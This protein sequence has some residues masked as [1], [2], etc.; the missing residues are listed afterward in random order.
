M[1]V[2]S[3]TVFDT[4][5]VPVRGRWGCVP[6]S[7]PG[8]PLTRRRR[9]PRPGTRSAVLARRARWRRSICAT[10]LSVGWSTRTS[11]F[12]QV[13]WAG[14]AL[15]RS[16]SNA[17]HCPKRRAWPTPPSWRRIDGLT[18]RAPPPRLRRP[19]RARGGVWSGGARGLRITAGLVVSDRVCAPIWRRPRRTCVRGR[20][21]AGPALARQGR[22]HRG[23][24]SR[25]HPALLEAC[26]ALLGD[27]ERSALHLAHQREPGGRGLVPRP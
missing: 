17:V 25:Q 14:Q 7:T 23:S 24:R 26:A 15:A 13:R 4:P 1:T 12:P 21:G 6:R 5:G 22:S 27:V 8:S 11:T 20:A 18:A 10:A 16:G 2:Y 9:G 3:T 19:L